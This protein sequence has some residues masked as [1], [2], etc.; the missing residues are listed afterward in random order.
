MTIRLVVSDVDGTLVRKDKS[1]SPQTIAAVHRLRAAG[2]PFTLIS[3]RPVSGVMPLVAA[4]ALDL[5]MA[6][7]NGGVLFRPDGSAIEEHPIERA[8]VVGGYDVDIVTAIGGRDRIVG[9]TRVDLEQD[10]AAGGAW[11]G[12]WNVGEW[13]EI[14]YEAVANLT[15]DAVIIYGNGGWEEAEQQLCRD[16]ADLAVEL[17]D[18]VALDPGNDRGALLLLELDRLHRRRLTCIPVCRSGSSARCNCCR[19]RST[20]RRAA[21]LSSRR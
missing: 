11:T 1:L 17:V 20:W 5:P 18:E 8:V 9:V 6:A 3:A 19:R 13:G 16:R 7:F 2:V 10:N 14:N 21:C 12:D 15:P 4:L